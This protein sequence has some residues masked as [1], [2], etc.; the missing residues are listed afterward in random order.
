LR[1]NDPG[2]H[3]LVVV[4]GGPVG[5]ATALYASRAGLD[6]RVLEARAG[7]IDK[8]CGEGLMPAAVA[9][10]ADLGVDP[11]GHAFRGIRYVAGAHVAEASFRAGPGRGVR[12]T[13]LHT[14]L[15]DAVREA[16]VSVTRHRVSKVQQDD[17]GVSV[18]DV[19]ARYVVAADGLHS[20]LRRMLGLDAPAHGAVRYGLRSH[21]RVAPWSDYVEVHWV[22]GAEAYVTPVA[23]DL[24]G[25]AVLT[26]RRGT[27]EEHISLFE[28]LAGL[29]RGRTTTPVLG[30]GPL[31]QRSR[32]RVAG[33][34]LLVGD[35]GG[36]VDALTGE[37]IAIG[38]AQA[39][40]AV[41]C[42]AGGDH[43][44]YDARARRLARRH[45]LLTHALLR[46][47]AH[48][49]LRRRLVPAAQRLPWVFSTAVNQLARPIEVSP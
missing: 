23:A 40:A 15:R 32:R 48:D 31:R 27:Y 47:T 28:G 16:G 39:R 2:V 34:V 4:G 41:A 10:L 9:A 36:Y 33:R 35:A 6:V 12:R 46:A 22:P 44:Q 49:V 8:A 11:P 18:D 25:V 17:D 20:P 30:A 37:G 38:L 7:T 24:V 14:A 5:L 3:D 42:I 45:E 13:V 43:E 29:V 26:D 21:V 19:R 1:R